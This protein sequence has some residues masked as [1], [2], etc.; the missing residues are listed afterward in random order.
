MMQSYIN[1]IP[2]AANLEQS[3]DKEF[4]TSTRSKS[5]F[6]ENKAYFATNSLHINAQFRNLPSGLNKTALLLTNCSYKKRQLIQIN[7]YFSNSPQN[8]GY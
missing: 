7:F 8:L 4:S 2:P 3:V 1:F 6:D 5:T